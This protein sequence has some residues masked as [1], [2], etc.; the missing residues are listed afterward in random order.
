MI[1]K[2]T[3]ESVVPG[4]RGGPLSSLVFGPY[5]NLLGDCGADG[6]GGHHYFKTFPYII[7]FFSYYFS[8]PFFYHDTLG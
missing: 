1:F 7:I 5:L 8:V 6:V 2:M 3:T 4:A